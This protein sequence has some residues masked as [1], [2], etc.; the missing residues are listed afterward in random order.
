MISLLLLNTDKYEIAVS[1][2]IMKIK[3]DQNA[4]F[5]KLTITDKSDPTHLY[6]RLPK[7][8]HPVGTY[9]SNYYKYSR[10]QL[11]NSFHSVF[12]LGYDIEGHAH[13]QSNRQKLLV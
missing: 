12:P 4:F 13:Y 7:Y 6:N 9:Q 11:R 10:D 2:N 1:N 3:D 5:M 8:F